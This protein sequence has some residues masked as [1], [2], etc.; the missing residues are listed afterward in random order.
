MTAEDKRSKMRHRGAKGREQDDH[1]QEIEKRAGS[2]VVCME[3][4]IR[5]EDQGL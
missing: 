3:G 4:Q 2:T 1:R 5:K